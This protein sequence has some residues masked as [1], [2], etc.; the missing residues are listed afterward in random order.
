MSLKNI[1]PLRAIA[2]IAVL[3]VAA[4]NNPVEHN[5]EHIDG[6]DGVEIT[7]IAGAV[8]ATY[9]EGAWTFTTG[10]ALHLH[11][12]EESEVRIYF[13][14]DDGDRFQVPLSGD[15]YTLRI[16]FDHP[17]AEYEGHSDHGHFVG[18]AAGETSANIQLYHGSHPD[19]ETDPR[20]PIEVVDHEH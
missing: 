7:D 17:I 8:I 12:D 4:C 15:E 9:A 3:G 11:P 6:A 18:L 14:A 5:D 20:L 16:D 13:I 2:L 19:F 1:S 10:D